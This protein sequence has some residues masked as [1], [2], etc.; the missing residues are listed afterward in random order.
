MDMYAFTYLCMCIGKRC[1]LESTGIPVLLHFK[2]LHSNEKTESARASR[3]SERT[4]PTDCDV[5]LNLLIDYS[6]ETMIIGNYD[7]TK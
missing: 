3:V 7:N 2:W 6:F 4:T 1:V 5:N